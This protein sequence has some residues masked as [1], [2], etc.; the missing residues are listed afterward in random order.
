MTNAKIKKGGNGL[1]DK[2]KSKI[3]IQSAQ[4][5][6]YYNQTTVHTNIPMHSTTRLQYTHKH[7]HEQNS[8][9]S[10]HIIININISMH[11]TT[12]QQYTHYKHYH[13]QYNQTKA[14]T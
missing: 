1:N 8:Q 4:Y 7:S 5:K 6:L 14:H 12:S 13:A 11:S 2:Y 9:C 3:K 10:T